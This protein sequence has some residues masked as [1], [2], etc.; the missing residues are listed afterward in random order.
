MNTIYYEIYRNKDFYKDIKYFI[1]DRLEDY[2][3]NEYYTC[4]LLHELTLN[5][6]MDGCYVFDTGS[7]IDFIKNNWEIAECTFNYYD[8]EIGMTINPFEDPCV[9]TFYML[10]YG[11]DQV[12]MQLDFIQDNWSDSIVINDSNI[13]EIT[14][15]LNELIKD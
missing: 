15:E 14:N 4:D 2:N 6:N 12:L 11:V 8:S 7:A 1:F 13:V 3:G 10:Q 5:E 9:Y